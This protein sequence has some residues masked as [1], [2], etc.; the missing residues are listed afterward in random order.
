MSTVRSTPD[1]AYDSVHSLAQIPIL[2]HHGRQDKI[3]EIIGPNAP[4]LIP[5]GVPRNAHG[6]WPK[7]GNVHISRK[8]AEKDGTL[9]DG[10]TK[11]GIDCAY[12]LDA[13]LMLNDNVPMYL[14]VTVV[15]LVPE[16]IEQKYIMRVTMLHHPQHAIYSR[17][18]DSA[19]PFATS[20]VCV[21]GNCKKVHRL[22]SW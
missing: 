2:V 18:R 10:L 22:G 1:E 21:C 12:E 9:P 8:H 3:Y 16:A 14:S 17:P 11:P 4:G 5:G 7:R 6:N 13:E 15:V 19:L 20:G